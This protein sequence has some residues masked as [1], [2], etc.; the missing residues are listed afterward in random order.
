MLSF[1]LELCQSS[2]VIS[3]FLAVKGLTRTLSLSENI[4]LLLN[5]LCG[6]SSSQYSRIHCTDVVFGDFYLP[7]AI[8]GN[9]LEQSNRKLTCS[10]NV[11]LLN[12]KYVNESH[13]T[14]NWAGLTLGL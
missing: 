5:F 10:L 4:L 7:D 12:H 1:P 6:R 2:P 13:W 8:I 14:G 11:L 3:R 9:L